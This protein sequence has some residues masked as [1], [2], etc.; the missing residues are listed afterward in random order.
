MP[1]ESQQAPS[2]EA[3]LQELE[4]V[5]KD[6][7]KGDLPLEKSMELFERG[8]AL[9]ADCKKQLEEAEMRVEV[10]MK[11]GSKTVAVPFDPDSENTAK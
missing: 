5:V 1:E 11:R 2:F 4:R 10:L 7:E 9:S 3:S 6:L 8:M